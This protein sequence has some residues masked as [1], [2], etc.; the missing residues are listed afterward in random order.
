MANLGSSLF[1]FLL[2]PDWDRS[3]KR[4][5]PPPSPPPQLSAV[6]HPRR[7]SGGYQNNNSN[8][9]SSISHN[10]RITNVSPISDENEEAVQRL[11]QQLHAQ[12]K[13]SKSRH[14]DCTEVLLP[15]DLLQ[16]I[17]SDMLEKSEK[18]PCGIRG[19]TIF[20]EFQEEPN[21]VRRIASLKPD[22]DCVSTFE[23][24]LTL[25]S[26]SSWTSKL[27]AF[28]KWV[29][30][31]SHRFNGG[32]E[33]SDSNLSTT[34]NGSIG[35]HSP[36]WSLS[37]DWS[38]THVTDIVYFC[39]CVLCNYIMRLGLSLQWMDGWMRQHELA[40]VALLN[41]TQ[42]TTMMMQRLHYDE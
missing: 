10:S 21:N 11:A 13:E 18:E 19:C 8:R 27:P 3:F 29:P 41:W 38:L 31:C 35:G 20:I 5:S 14:L 37:E 2:H 30:F 42:P 4:P 9:S 23:F 16:R 17:A 7:Q 24:Y 32:S 25:N 15:T 34:E 36:A 22:Q 12:L 26:Q 6:S 1:R 40:Q 28:L 39:N 33:E